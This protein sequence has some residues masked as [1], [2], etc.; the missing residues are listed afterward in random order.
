MW[1]VSQLW[2]TSI[3]R[4][5]KYRAKIF[6]IFFTT[7]EVTLLIGTRKNNVSNK[8]IGKRRFSNYNL[9]L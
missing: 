9:P 8:L 4:A 1:E 6:I 7:Y 3:F 5:I 2:I